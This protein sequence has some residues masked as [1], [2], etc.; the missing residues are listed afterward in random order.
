MLN[1]FKEFLAR[2]NVVDLAVAVVLG[3][4]FAAVVHSLV[5]DVITPAILARLKGQLAQNGGVRPAPP[6]S[7][8]RPGLPP[9][10]APR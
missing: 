8:S 1:E 4:A 9:Q 2:G 6:N 3:A 10:Q 7:A 5:A